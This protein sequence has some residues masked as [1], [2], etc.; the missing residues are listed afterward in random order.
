MEIYIYLH[1]RLHK[2][3]NQFIIVIYLLFKVLCNKMKARNTITANRM[4]TTTTTKYKI[5]LET[6]YSM[7]EQIIQKSHKRERATEREMVYRIDRRT[8]SHCPH[9]ATIQIF[10]FIVLVCNVASPS[11][12][13]NILLGY[14]N[15]TI[16]Y[17]RNSMI[18]NID[19][20]HCMIN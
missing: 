20:I 9:I 13:S 17:I 18:E 19:I 15:Y 4:C 3:F 1:T 10:I 14:I 12:G 8:L 11:I 7:I 2:P 5:H 16:D 6:V